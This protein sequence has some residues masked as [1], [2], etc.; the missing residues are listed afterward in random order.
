MTTRTKPP[1]PT[2]TAARDTAVSARQPVQSKPPAAVLS[3]WIALPQPPDPAARRFC[4]SLSGGRRGRRAG[5]LDGL[6]HLDRCDLE[7]RLIAAVEMEWKAP[8]EG[9]S[10]PDFTRALAHSH[11][12]GEAMYRDGS[13]SAG[14]DPKLDDVSSLHLHRPTRRACQH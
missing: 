6:V 8:C 1:A 7:M 9:R 10:E 2:A 13:F 4:R 14:N 5:R 11:D 3:P 12:V